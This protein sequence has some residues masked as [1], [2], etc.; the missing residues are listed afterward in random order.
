[1]TEYVTKGR[2]P[3]D[4]TGEAM[5]DS[6]WPLPTQYEREPDTYVA[7]D[8]RTLK[9]LG[10]GDYKVLWY[11]AT[12]ETDPGHLVIGPIVSR[13]TYGAFDM[14]E[15]QTLAGTNEQ[16][17]MAVVNQIVEKAQGLDPYPTPDVL[18]RNRGQAASFTPT[19]TQPWA[20]PEKPVK[21]PDNP[22]TSEPLSRPKAGTAT[23][24]VWEVADRLCV[25]M[26]GKQLRQAV[27]DECGQH[28]INPST[29]QVQFGKWRKFRDQ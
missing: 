8:R 1:M 23:G 19:Y 17:W 12:K 9:I 29:A 6:H 14:N 25:T 5:G 28:G 4:P 20:S 27:I 21:R 26:S 16:D 24:R 15:L 18:F 3:T 2:H 7:I 10:T 22:V 11:E 13:F